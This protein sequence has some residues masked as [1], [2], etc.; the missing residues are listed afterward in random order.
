MVSNQDRFSIEKA[1]I[2]PN[3]VKRIA[4]IDLDLKESGHTTFEVF[5]GLG[6]RVYWDDKGN[7]SEGNYKFDLQTTNFGTGL[8]FLKIKS[9]EK[10]KVLKFIKL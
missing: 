6:Q 7:L 9:G 1:S 2:F 8:Y 5:N 4:T 3:P 10:Q